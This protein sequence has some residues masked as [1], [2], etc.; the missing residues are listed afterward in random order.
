VGWGWVYQAM[1]RFR[2]IPT[3]I[4]ICWRWVLAN[5]IWRGGLPG[6]LE[7]VTVP[8]PV[9]PRRSAAGMGSSLGARQRRS[10][11]SSRAQARTHGKVGHPVL[12]VH[13]RLHGP[14]GAEAPPG[15]KLLRRRTVQG[16]ERAMGRFLRQ[17]RSPAC[18]KSSR[19]PLNLTLIF[20]LSFL[21]LFPRLRTVFCRYKNN[22]RFLHPSPIIQ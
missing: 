18:Q 22:A 20:V 3:A 7:G 13:A 15:Q 10:H 16:R 9:S 6:C 19:P 12:L 1:T 5:P 11:A 17:R 2:L 4:K 8:E 21:A 14:R